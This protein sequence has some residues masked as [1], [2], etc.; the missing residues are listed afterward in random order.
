MLRESLEDRA[1]SRGRLEGHHRVVA[2]VLGTTDSAATHERLGRHLLAAGDVEGALAV[3]GRATEAATDDSDPA[4]ASAV[5]ALWEEAATRAG[6][7]EEDP[8]RLS[9]WIARIGVASLTR[10]AASQ[11][12]WAER[13]SAVG[14]AKGWV[15]WEARGLV[16]EAA[17][18]RNAGRCQEALAFLATAEPLLVGL[19]ADHPLRRQH[20]IQAGFAKTQLG[21]FEGGTEAFVR[22][23][24]IPGDMRP[25]TGLIWVA[26]QRR[27]GPAA[28]HWGER[29]EAA[30]AAYRSTPMDKARLL[31][32]LAMVAL[33]NGEPERGARLG[34]DAVTRYE[35]LGANP[36]P[37]LYFHGM[38]LVALERWGEARGVLLRV[39]AEAG[40]WQGAQLDAHVQL[41]CCAAGAG[42]WDAWDTSMR[43]L[44][45]L[46]GRV[47]YGDVSAMDA[48]LK[49]AKMAAAKGQA[50]RA[51]RAEQIAARIAPGGP[52]R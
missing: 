32:D 48:T 26:L 34:Q 36:T 50:N 25:Y 47:A 35:R 46:V 16:Y 23:V 28:R 40:P 3:L 7:P 44:E 4:R 38:C 37:P 20:L 33:F 19:S 2:A 15:D 11:V 14:R 49:A 31:T 52:T 39:I 45:G 1:R 5:L 42:D 41:A 30:V 10:D 43:E 27:D 17:A 24:E 9:S 29:A 22:A 51:T 12:R 21:D 13:M 6:V 18:A 8:R